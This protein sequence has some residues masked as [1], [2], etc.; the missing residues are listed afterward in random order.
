[1]KLTKNLRKIITFTIASFLLLEPVS[2]FA[3]S[4]RYETPKEYLTEVK[5]QGRTG[6]CWAH[7]TMGAIEIA[8]KKAT[9]RTVDL[10]ETHL[11]YHIH[12]GAK[13]DGASLTSATPY[14]MRLDGPVGETE[15]PTI[16]DSVPL[17]QNSGTYV[18]PGHNS[19]EDLGKYKYK[20]AVGNIIESDIS[21]VKE[22][23][24]K[25]GAVTAA[26]YDNTESGF[27]GNY[28]ASGSYYGFGRKSN[29]PERLKRFFYNP[30]L[31][32]HYAP[33]PMNEIVMAPNHAVVLVGWD[34]NKEIVNQ[35]GQRAVGAF[36]VRQSRGPEFG[37]NGYMWISY[38]TFPKESF[39]VL[40][41]N[42]L[43]VLSPVKNT[44]YSYGNFL[45]KENSRKVYTFGKDGFDKSSLGH[46]FK[47]TTVDM[48]N[49]YNK[50]DNK[51][52]YLTNIQFINEVGKNL[53]YEIQVAM[54]NGHSTE[55]VEK[56][57]YTKVAS[58]VSNDKGV[59]TISISPLEIT[60]NKFAIR[61]ILKNEN[62]V[63]ISI[64]KDI[65]ST[66]S[67]IISTPTYTPD[68]NFSFINTDY[69]FIPYN[70]DIYINAFT[71][72]D[73]KSS[74]NSL[75]EEKVKNVISV[76]KDKETFIYVDKNA[77]ES[78]VREHLLSI[79]NK[80]RV[81]YTDEKGIMQ[82]KVFEIK[83]YVLKNGYF[84]P[85]ITDY[86]DVDK[87]LHNSIRDKI[88]KNEDLF[89]YYVY[90]NKTSHANRYNV[91]DRNYDRNNYIND[92]SYN[93]YNRNISRQ[94]RNNRSSDIFREAQLSKFDKTVLTYKLQ[95]NYNKT[96]LLTNTQKED[97]K[98][99][100]NGA[101]IGAENIRIIDDILYIELYNEL[102]NSDRIEVSFNE[103]SISRY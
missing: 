33:N 53:S 85:I 44:F 95:K 103:N 99:R 89:K 62:G 39:Q 66:G 38:D 65:K 37:D 56:A 45:S 16:K 21:N 5:N 40:R 9:G 6:T 46:T 42:G 30:D 20:F 7:A 51:R 15:Y 60:K 19:M 34:D 50:N 55:D 97:V 36:K 61:L 69:G 101:L 26:Y 1:M 71:Q 59:N 64:A 23:I 14:L 57:N 76:T 98:I 82:S 70:N 32:Y 77:S 68:S 12:D 58:G 73:N 87:D 84:V 35:R 102:S 100:V 81:D 47:R 96:V 88:N 8:Y 91:E 54:L 74:F 80:L 4:V 29:E 52:E 2:A 31:V 13:L 11:A 92:N 3:V 83:D 86:T 41:I 18:L 49:V 79:G 93:S 94:N 17:Y 63:Y 22:N 48:V 90:L 67:S 27:S 10:S 24:E 43:D 78:Y 28:N 25:Y 75:Y 72:S